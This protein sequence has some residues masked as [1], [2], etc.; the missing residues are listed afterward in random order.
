MK[1]KRIVPLVLVSLGVLA[2]S[3]SALAFGGWGSGISKATP[4]EQAQHF[5]AMMSQQAT[6]LGITSDQMKAYWAEGKPMPEIMT[7][8]GLTKEQLQTK[9]QEMRKQ[10]MQEHLQ[11]LVSQGVITQAQADTRFAALES[12]TAKGFGGMMG[13]RGMRGGDH[14]CPFAEGG[15]P[16][17]Q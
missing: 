17:A 8:L 12:K 13:F 4:E 16:I 15:Q 7:E 3:G 9:M 10:N 1:T 2:L 6:M 11:T 14:P 5:T